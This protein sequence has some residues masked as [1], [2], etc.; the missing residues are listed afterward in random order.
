MGDLTALE[1]AGWDLRQ[2]QARETPTTSGQILASAIA[3]VKHRV[4]EH[5][6]AIEKAG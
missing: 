5:F 4:A 1:A 2:L 6:D 3:K